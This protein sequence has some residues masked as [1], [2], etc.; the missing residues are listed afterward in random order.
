MKIKPTETVTIG[1]VVYV[2]ATQS[3]TVK[4]LVDVYD[5]IRKDLE[6]ARVNY[7]KCEAA[8][9]DL[10]TKIAAEIQQNVAQTE[11]VED[12]DNSRSRV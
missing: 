9:R 4:S 2:V 8:L 6:N 12:D 11:E 10:G 1:E 7:I 5:E 3:E